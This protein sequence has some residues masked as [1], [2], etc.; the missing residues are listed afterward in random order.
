M[1]SEEDWKS[2]EFRIFIIAIGI[3]L[4]TYL[5]MYLNNIPNKTQ[6]SLVLSLGYVIG[7]FLLSV[8][9]KIWIKYF[10]K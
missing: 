7:V 1:A 5:T 10:Y 2:S 9:K 6:G 4:I 8:A 3:F